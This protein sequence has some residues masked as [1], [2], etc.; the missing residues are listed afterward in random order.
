MRSDE[1]PTSCLHFTVTY[2]PHVRSSITVSN[3]H[4]P[5]WT[6]AGPG[7]IWSYLFWSPQR[8]G[9]G[10]YVTPTV[11][12]SVITHW[13]P[14]DPAQM[15]CPWVDPPTLSLLLTPN[16]LWYPIPV[17]LPPPPPHPSSTRELWHPIPVLCTAAQPEPAIV[18]CRSPH[19]R[20]TARFVLF[21][22]TLHALRVF[23]ETRFPKTNRISVGNWFRI[24]KTVGIKS[25]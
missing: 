22:Y 21:V 8:R 13:N 4:H 7:I 17:L 10:S 23:A 20:T 12:N 15:S 18:Y 1:I 2:H 19:P 9:P 16:K 3:T 24:A 6:P 11:L 14:L 25:E 5:V